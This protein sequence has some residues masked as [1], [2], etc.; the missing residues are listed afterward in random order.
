MR[1]K[2]YNE[3][4]SLNLYRLHMSPWIPYQFNMTLPFKGNAETSKKCNV[5][6]FAM[7]Y[8]IK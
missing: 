1:T 2:K 3:D 4:T 5:A 6:T 7:I 8:S